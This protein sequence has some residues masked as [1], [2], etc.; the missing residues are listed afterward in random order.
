MKIQKISA[1]ALIALKDALANVYWRKKELRQFIELTVENSL[2]VS[3]IDWQENPKYESVSQLIDRMAARQDLYLNDL[4]KLL[5]ETSNIND[6][7][8]L[9]YWDEKGN[10]TKR[11][12]EAV[13][14]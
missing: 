5:Q 2:I 4:L 10:L 13:A 6:F 8:H 3:T 9:K 12:I 7:S 14:K 1:Q 11:A